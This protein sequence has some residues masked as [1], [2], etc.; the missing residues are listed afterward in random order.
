MW[1]QDPTLRRQRPE[2]GGLKPSPHRREVKGNETRPEEGHPWERPS[3]NGDRRPAQ[4]CAV[5][6]H[7]TLTLAVG[8]KITYGT[9]LHVF[10]AWR[11]IRQSHAGHRIPPSLHMKVFGIRLRHAPHVVTPA[12][13]FLSFLRG[14]CH[15]LP[16]VCPIPIYSTTLHRVWLRANR[17]RL[18]HRTRRTTLPH[19]TE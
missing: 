18:R 8:H 7:F 10:C 9:T 15:A 3:R 16:H 19:L 12:G 1:Y 5:T 6:K 11:F 2:Q 13:S 17:S 4:K 14:Q